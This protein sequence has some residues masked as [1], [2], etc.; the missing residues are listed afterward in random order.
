MSPGSDRGTESPRESG[1]RK[2]RD[3]R[4]TLMARSTRDASMR[5][6]IGEGGRWVGANA[7]ERVVFILHGL[8]RTEGETRRG[9][10][11][12]GQRHTKE[13]M[14]NRVRVSLIEGPE[15][16]WRWRAATKDQIA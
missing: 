3:P 12:G 4:R 11:W 9:D 1:Q 10:A 15:K 5:K 7:G 16:W 13:A 2:D 14:E 6:R 8:R